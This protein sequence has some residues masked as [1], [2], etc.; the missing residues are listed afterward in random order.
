M[1]GSFEFSNMGS[2]P[3]ETELNGLVFFLPSKNSKVT[4][5]SK[6]FQKSRFTTASVLNRGSNHL[7][8]LISVKKY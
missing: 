4:G 5:Q 8:T 2:D 6:G 1:F 3:R 7:F